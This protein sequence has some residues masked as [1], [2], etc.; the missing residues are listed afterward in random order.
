MNALDIFFVLFLIWGIWNGFKKGLIIELFTFLA[1]FLGLYAGIHFSDFVGEKISGNVDSS[2]APV[3]AF[4][5]TFLAVG[6]MVY[7]GGKAIEKVVKIVQLSLLN[8]LLGAVF[9]L[10]KATFLLGA[11]IMIFDSYDDRN[12]FIDD[13]TKEGS[14][15]YFPAKNVLSFCIPAFEESSLYIK[16]ALRDEELLNGENE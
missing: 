8:K 7:F 6:A 2:Y 5:I 3:I 13:S 15:F 1:L 4:T 12:D 14:L 9:G 11:L 10:L 16:D